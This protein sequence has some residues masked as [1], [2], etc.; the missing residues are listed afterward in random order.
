MRDWKARLVGFGSDGAAVNLGSKSGV[1]AR[2]KQEVEHLVSIHCTADRLELGVVGA[3]RPI[4]SPC[5][6][7]ISVVIA[8]L[9]IL[10]TQAVFPSLNH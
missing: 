7:E 3:I 1:A 6:G 5:S 9:R 4:S 2:L 8:L 10:R